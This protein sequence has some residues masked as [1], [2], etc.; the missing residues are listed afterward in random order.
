[1]GAASTLNVLAHAICGDRPPVCTLNWDGISVFRARACPL[2]LMTLYFKCFRQSP[3]HAAAPMRRYRNRSANSNMRINIRIYSACISLELCTHKLRAGC[4]PSVCALFRVQYPPNRTV[5]LLFHSAKLYFWLFLSCSSL[6][7]AP[8]A[9]CVHMACI[10]MYVRY[11][12]GAWRNIT[13]SICGIVS[14]FGQ[15]F[16]QRICSKFFRTGFPMYHRIGVYMHM[17][18]VFG[19]KCVCVCACH[20]LCKHPNLYTHLGPFP[21]VLLTH[22]RGRHLGLGSPAIIWYAC[23]I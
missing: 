23:T 21:F 3:V 12:F 4:S 17:D 2:V 11:I 5:C 15:M 9:I 1:M 10:I 13:L 6:A 22:E 16:L 14:I 20:S 7:T 19:R 8:W 18:A